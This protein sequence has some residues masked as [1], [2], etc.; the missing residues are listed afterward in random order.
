MWR[1]RW[2]GV[3]LP[4]PAGA[5]AREEEP[6]RAER[7]D[8]IETDPPTRY[9]GSILQLHYLRARELQPR[10]GRFAVRGEVVVQVWLEPEETVVRLGTGAEWE[11]ERIP[12]RLRRFWQVRRRRRRKTINFRPIYLFWH[13]AQ[14]PVSP[15]PDKTGREE[16]D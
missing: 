12:E 3:F 4:P 2:L 16:S 8:R 9:R 15:F 11:V 5:A 6:A 10:F 13:W 1:G 14:T 7:L